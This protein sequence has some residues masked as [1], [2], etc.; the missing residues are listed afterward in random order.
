MCLYFCWPFEFVINYKLLLSNCS[1]FHQFCSLISSA[2]T[3][4]F[5][6]VSVLSTSLQRCVCFLVAFECLRQ[7]RLQDQSLLLAAFL[8]RFVSL[9]LLHYFAN[10]ASF[11]L[12]LPLVGPLSG[13]SYFGLACDAVIFYP[14]QT[15][16]L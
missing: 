6:A 13:S 2:L 9:L 7:Q 12:E 1:K 3:F 11:L 5:H 4:D 14:L 15:T 16:D 10:I 8:L